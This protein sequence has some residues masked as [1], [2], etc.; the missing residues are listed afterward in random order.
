MW[1]PIESFPFSFTA[2]VVV[3]IV[4]TVVEVVV[5]IVIVVVTVVDIVFHLVNVV[6]AVVVA[7]LLS[8]IFLLLTQQCVVQ[9]KYLF[10]LWWSLLSLLSSVLSFS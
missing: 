1:H 10:L 2:M 7:T 6:V 5:Y 9:L 4:V 3:I 8:S